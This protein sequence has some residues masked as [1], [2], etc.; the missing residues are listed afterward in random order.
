MAQVASGTDQVKG[1]GNTFQSIFFLGLLLFLI[2]LSLNVVADR[3]VRRV[4]QK[5]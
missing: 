5:Y 1:V 3:F 2:T 4:R